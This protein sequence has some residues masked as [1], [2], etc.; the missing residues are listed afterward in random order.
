LNVFPIR[1]PPLRERITDIPAMLQYFIEK[2]AK[3]LKLP[4]IPKLAPGAIE[5]LLNYEW[6]GNV[7]ELEN[8]VERALILNPLGPVSFD[9]LD[10]VSIS[11][12]KT[13]SI[14]SDGTETLDMVTARYIK[15]V[16]EKTNGKINGKDGAARIL[17]VNPNTLRNRMIKLGI[18]FGR[19]IS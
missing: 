18:P 7:R 16:L 2:K 10:G 19:E 17:G 14:I 15:Q 12:N 11:K 4:G 5:P 6:K 1:I 3:E 13:A 8:I 9:N